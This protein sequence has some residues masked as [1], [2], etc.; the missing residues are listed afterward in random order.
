MSI[1]PHNHEMWAVIGIYAGQEDNAFYRPS[2][3]PEA[4]T[5]VWSAARSSPRGDVAV[6]SDARLRRD[7]PAGSPHGGHPRVQRRLHQRA[8]RRVGAGPRGGCTDVDQARRRFSEAN[9]RLFASAILI[10]C[11]H[12]R[13]A[14]PDVSD[15]PPPPPPPLPPSRGGGPTSTTT[16]ARASGVR[17]PPDRLAGRADRR[18]AEH[19]DRA[20]LVHRS[21]QLRWWRSPPSTGARCGKGSGTG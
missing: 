7:E 5:L 11:G 12:A 19:D 8:A 1:Y 13:R 10:W 17:R 18:V 16:A 20:V 21:G 6:L 9:G 14:A 4:R 2:A 3:A 15:P